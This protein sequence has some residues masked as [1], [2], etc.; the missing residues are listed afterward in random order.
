[1][2]L[3]VKVKKYGAYPQEDFLFMK[4]IQSLYISGKQGKVMEIKIIWKS[5]GKKPKKA[6]F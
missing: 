1:L 6:G 3:K 5:Q 4:F 2:T